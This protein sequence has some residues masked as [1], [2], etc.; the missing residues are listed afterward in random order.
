MR[1][2]RV[3]GEHAGSDCVLP[4]RRRGRIFPGRVW[5]GM[6]HT[7]A[8]RVEISGGFSGSA[9]YRYESLLTGSLAEVERFIASKI[10]GE[11]DA[12][13]M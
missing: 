8:F 3:R 1:L 12:M 9:A 4:V 7:T 13:M 10:E 2:H 6:A 11:Q 5:Q